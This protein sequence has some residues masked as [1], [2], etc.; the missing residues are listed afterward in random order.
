MK[1]EN[2][3]LASV[4]VL[5][6]LSGLIFQHEN[7]YKMTA[8]RFLII[9]AAIVLCNIGL[10]FRKA[11][12]G[13]RSVVAQ[14][15][16]LALFTLALMQCISWTRVAEYSDVR[17]IGTGIAALFFILVVF[18]GLHL[19]LEKGINENTVTLII[20]GGFLIRMFMAVM[21]QGHVMQNDIGAL[22]A[23]DDGHM[24]YVYQIFTSGM[25]PMKNPM[26]RNQLYH[27]PLHY[28]VSAIL[29]RIYAFLGIEQAAWDEALQAL[30]IFCSTA[31]LVFLDKTAQKLR[32]SVLG[33]CIIVGLAAFFP[34]SVY[35]GFTLNNDTPA[36]LFMVMC[37]YF[38]LK[39]KEEPTLKNILCMA[40]CI[41]CGMMTKLSAAM[42][43]PA[44]AVVM[45]WTAWKDRKQWRVWLK[46][47]ICFGL[48]S[49]PLGLWYSAFRW[50]QYRMPFGYV[51]KLS[52]VAEQYVG[53]YS[54]STRFRGWEHALESLIIRWGPAPNVDYNIPVT[55]LKFA[56]FGESSYYD[57]EAVSFFLG[58]TAFWSTLAL[59]VLFAAAFAGWLFMRKSERAEEKVF[60]GLGAAVILFAYVSF[61]IRY[62]HVCTM[63][64]RYVMTAI[65][66]G[67]LVLGRT[68]SGIQEKLETRNM[69]VCRIFSVLTGSIAAAY[70]LLCILLNV[71]FERLLF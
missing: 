38:T 14:C 64:V 35:T 30:P 23:E 69:K 42:I 39:W 15:S 6:F 58:T 12:K 21:T 18:C 5:A 57:H 55:M 37:I 59:F 25:I 45:L 53:M 34:Y 44:M 3:M 50:F 48:V 29:L 7:D 60:L 67:I 43:A 13:Q 11:D 8:M 46:Q 26:I 65:Y 49:F 1:R 24:G 20:F 10:F 70:I 47:F 68:V 33:R 19:L 31:T 9:A 41:G 63:N 52:E 71:N 51:P 62:P 2:R 27:P 66:I 16:I 22:R 17:G 28:I 32:C 4:A 54:A 36:A 40:V 56:V 61:C